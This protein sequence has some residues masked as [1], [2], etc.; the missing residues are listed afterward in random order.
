[1]RRGWLAIRQRS[2]GAKEKMMAVPLS[3]PYTFAKRDSSSFIDAVVEEERTYL[4]LLLSQTPGTLR[5]QRD[6]KKGR[7]LPAS[8]LGI[9]PPGT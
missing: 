5:G 6:S 8:G 3:H 1:M 7:R 4:L 2:A 9:P